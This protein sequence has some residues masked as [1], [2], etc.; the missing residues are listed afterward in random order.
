MAGRTPG[1]RAAAVTAV[2]TVWLAA[3]AIAAAASPEQ[4]YVTHCMGCH[5]PTGAGVP[6]RIP[7]LRDSLGAFVRSTAGQAYLTRVPGASN[8]SLSDA[9][10][11]AVLT[12][13]AAR[14][15]PDQPHVFTT[16][17]VARNRRPP[18]S[19]VREARTAL[20]RSLAGSGPLPP[21]EY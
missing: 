2:S 21:E 8:S 14:Y 9:Q 12:W 6:G 11:A 7:A 20:L 15:A 18:L 3:P 17:E 19:N 13:L 16:D 1:W 4:D 5:G 10:L